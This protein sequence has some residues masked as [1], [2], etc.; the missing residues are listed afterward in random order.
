MFS[1]FKGCLKW[2]SDEKREERHLDKGKNILDKWHE[3]ELALQGKENGLKM[4]EQ[5]MS[6]VNVIKHYIQYE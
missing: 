2:K 6:S 4:E 3:I 1:T 5:I